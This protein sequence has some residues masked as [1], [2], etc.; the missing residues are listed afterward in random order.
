LHAA[1]AWIV[2]HLGLRA[3]AA[4]GLVGESVAIHALTL[5]SIGGLTIGMMT[6][7]AKGPPGGLQADGYESAPTGW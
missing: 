4:A 3:L 7:T 1:Y 2:I 6:R 5:G